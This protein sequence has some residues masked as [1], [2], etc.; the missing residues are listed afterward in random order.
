MKSYRG[1]QKVRPEKIDRLT[2]QDR[3]T[4]IENTETHRRGVLKRIV[5]LVEDDNKLPIM[6]TWKENADPKLK[7]RVK[8]QLGFIQKD[9]TQL[10]DIPE[11]DIVSKYGLAYGTRSSNGG[12]RRGDASKSK[13]SVFV[14][15]GGSS[16]NPESEN[17]DATEV[18]LDNDNVFM[19]RSIAISSLMRKALSSVARCS[20][21]LFVG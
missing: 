19:L 7:A 13:E 5:P 11:V 18:D 2:A 8:K 12:G 17:W 10:T 3:V 9:F 6:F 14:Y 15:N 16:W 1:H 20:T 4:L 21:L